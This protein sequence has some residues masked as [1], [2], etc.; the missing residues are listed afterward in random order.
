MKFDDRPT[1][2][3]PPGVSRGTWDY[4]STPSI[5][6]EYDAFHGDHP[7]MLRVYKD[8]QR[9]YFATGLSCSLEYWDLPKERPKTKHPNKNEIIS[10]IQTIEKE[11]LD[12]INDFKFVGKN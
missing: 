4:V 7:L 3:L 5:A 8:G 12:K 11:F 9:K 10:R 2:Q 1:W 6:T